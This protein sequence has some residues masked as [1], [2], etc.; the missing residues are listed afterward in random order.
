MSPKA[1]HSAYHAYAASSQFF[2]VYL[3]YV[4]VLSCSPLHSQRIFLVLYSAACPKCLLCCWGGT[5]LLPTNFA[6]CMRERRAGIQVLIMTLQKLSSSFLQT[7]TVNTLSDCI[8]QYLYKMF[9]LHVYHILKNK[10]W[11]L[12]K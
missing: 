11:L 8:L 1:V 4:S 10:Q 5:R 9:T 6:E 2:I 3:H 12:I 7:G